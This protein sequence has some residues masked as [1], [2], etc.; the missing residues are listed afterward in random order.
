VKKNTFWMLVLLSVIAVILAHSSAR[1]YKLMYSGRASAFIDFLMIML[2]VSWVAWSSSRIKSKSKMAFFLLPCYLIVMWFLWLM[3][4]I[5]V[6]YL[7]AICSSVQASYS[8]F[9]Y[10]FVAMYALSAATMALALPGIWWWRKRD[11]RKTF[12]VPLFMAHVVFSVFIGLLAFGIP[13][14]YR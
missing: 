2:F 7:M 10:R 11:S 3:L 14:T 4:W 6:D 1:S 13:P 12:Y 9:T 8:A 5:P